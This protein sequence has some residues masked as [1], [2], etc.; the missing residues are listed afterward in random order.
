MN[1]FLYIVFL[2]SL[3]KHDVAYLAHSCI[4]DSP[5]LGLENNEPAIFGKYFIATTCMDLA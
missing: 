3:L 2:A 5:P 4:Q 1:L